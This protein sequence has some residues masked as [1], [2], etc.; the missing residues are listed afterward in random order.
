MLKRFIHKSVSLNRKIQTST[1]SHNDA[2]TFYEIG[3]EYLNTKHFPKAL[4]YLQK[5]STGGVP[6]AN[7]SLAQMYE[8]GLGVNKDLVKAES[9]YRSALSGGDHSAHL[10]LGNLIKSHDNVPLA[11][12]EYQKAVLADIPDSI[13]PFVELGTEQVHMLQ[14]EA[15]GPNYL[16]YLTLI[17]EK[18]G[19]D[20]SGPTREYPSA[21][22][23]GR[24]LF[25]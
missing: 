14:N 25:Q 20:N 19:L 11:F 12:V 24:A 5:A 16:K 1:K 18:Y 15:F 8:N 21:I 3:V 4:D 10:F 17:F 23:V 6:Q 9:Y 22:F 7:I 13:T 2:L